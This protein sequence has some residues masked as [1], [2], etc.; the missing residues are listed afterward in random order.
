MAFQKRKTALA[1]P[2]TPFAT[3]TL[4]FTV[5]F[6]SAIEHGGKVTDAKIVAPF[7]DCF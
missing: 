4:S 1:D 3:Y 7:A 6:D 2:R 5:T